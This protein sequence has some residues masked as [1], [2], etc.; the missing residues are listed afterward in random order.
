MFCLSTEK[1]GWENID[2]TSTDAGGTLIFGVAA[3]G[4]APTYIPP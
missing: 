3:T 2:R 4:Y 1:I